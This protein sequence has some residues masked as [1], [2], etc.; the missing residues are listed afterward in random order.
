V[1]TVVVRPIFSRVG[2]AHRPD[3]LAVSPQG[4]DRG[5]TDTVGEFDWAAD[6]WGIRLPIKPILPK[7]RMTGRWWEFANSI[8]C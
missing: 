1:G 6:Y 5:A 2:T 8:V 4:G 3:R 7:L